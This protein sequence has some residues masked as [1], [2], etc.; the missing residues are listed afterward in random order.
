[1]F[2]FILMFSSI[3]HQISKIELFAKIANDWKPLTI[4]E[5]SS[6]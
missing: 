3:L 1:M 5:K 2:T 4:F 6:I